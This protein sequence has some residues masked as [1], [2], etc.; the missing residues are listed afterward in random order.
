M[1]TITTKKALE[2]EGE[3]SNDEQFMKKGKRGG[4]F[5]TCCIDRKNPV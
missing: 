3:T 4:C 2:T 5:V 1:K